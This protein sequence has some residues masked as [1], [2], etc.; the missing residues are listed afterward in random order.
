[1]LQ[2]LTGGGRKR[3]PDLA[4]K[5][6]PE[7]FSGARSL[8]GPPTTPVNLLCRIRTCNQIPIHV[9]PA[10]SSI[11][12]EQGMKNGWYLTMYLLVILSVV[13]SVISI[14]T[15]PEIV[16]F[17]WDIITG[18]IYK[19]G[20]GSKWFHSRGFIYC[21]LLCLCLWEYVFVP[22]SSQQTKKNGLLNRQS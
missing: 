7:P 4:K 17:R 9:G 14:A 2:P 21:F 18:E 3:P 16:P 8:Q 5:A 13:L 15:L 19:S 20:M 22:L 11:E 1:L 12:G 6:P 10:Y